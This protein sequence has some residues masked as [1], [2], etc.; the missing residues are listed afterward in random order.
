MSVKIPSMSPTATFEISGADLKAIVT[1]EIKRKLSG[2]YGD[3][4]LTVSFQMLG[5]SLKDADIIAKVDF[6]V[7]PR[8][9]ESKFTRGEDG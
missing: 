4:E 9:I 3:V 8:A 1:D 2:L 6:I 5:S 7:K